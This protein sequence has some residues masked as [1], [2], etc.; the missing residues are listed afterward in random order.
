VVA[1]VSV[2]IDTQSAVVDV[3]VLLFELFDDKEPLL[4]FL[5]FSYFFCINLA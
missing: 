1:V 2:F 5:D 3:A 4:L